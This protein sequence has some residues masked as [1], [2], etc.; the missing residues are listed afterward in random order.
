M[1]PGNMEV[2]QSEDWEDIQHISCKFAP[3][4]LSYERA[5]R[6]GLYHV[7]RPESRRRVR[8]CTISRGGCVQG[9]S[10]GLYAKGAKSPTVS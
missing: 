8:P 2:Y 9:A 1:V 5:S 4:L 7:L 6:L 10:G 3:F